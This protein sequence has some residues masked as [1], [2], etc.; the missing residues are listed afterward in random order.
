[1]IT[2]VTLP[3]PTGWVK[4]ATRIR[5]EPMTEPTHLVGTPQPQD[6]RL[7]RRQMLADDVYEAIKTMLMDHVIRPG[8]RISIDGL[9]REFQVSSTPVREALARLESEGLAVKE[10][11]KGYRATPLLSLAEFDDL[12]RFRQL[13][14]PWAAR[15]AAELIDAEGRARLKAELANA[16]EPTSVDYAGYKS[17]TA[18]DNRFHLLIAALS[19]SEQVR[20][21]FERTHCHLHIFRLHYDRDIG[22]EVLTEHRTLVEAIT[23]GDPTAAESA[24]TQHIENSMSHRLRRIYE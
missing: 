3:N 4:A 19:G 10:P 7:L 13:L 5:R 1:M 16:V 15:R 20:L 6:R 11:L 21:A 2:S 24:M 8:A 14:E 22:P 23:S 9:A 12:Y 18:H 17:L